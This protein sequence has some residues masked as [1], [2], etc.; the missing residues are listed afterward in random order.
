[1]PEPTAA[2]PTAQ[3][4]AANQL[5]LGRRLWRAARTTVFWLTALYLGGLLILLGLMHWWGERNWL[6]SLLLFA[7]PHW[8]LLPSVALAPFCLVLHPR[9]VLVHAASAALV[10]FGYMNFRWTDPPTADPRHLVVV[11]HNVGQGDRRQFLSF[12]FAQ[13]PEFIALQ[14]ARSRGA[15]YARTFPKFHVAGRGEFFLISKHQIRRADFVE[16]AKWNN[17]PVAARYEVLREGTP[18]VIYNVH[19]PTPRAQFNRFRSGRAIADIVR[20]DDPPGVVDYVQWMKARIRLAEE[21]AEVFAAEKQPFIACGDFNTPDHGYIYRILTRDLDDAH[22]TAGH[23]W[24]FTFPGD[25]R[26]PL[27]LARPWL[28]IDYA[29]AGQGWT[30]VYCAADPGRRSQ[31]RAVVARFAVDSRS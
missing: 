22:R 28:R 1:M 30:P 25:T 5:S 18:L 13:S 9:L 6:L 2:P 7:P 19:L 27:A 29:F 8:L 17:R 20:E 16:G 26:N 12:V 31:H 11:T 3:L 14:D 23:G 15:D 10:L 24:G 21:L 4:A